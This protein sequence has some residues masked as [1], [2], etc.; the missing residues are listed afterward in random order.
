MASSRPGP[1]ELFLATRP[2]S[3]LNSVSKAVVGGVLGL[4]AAGVSARTISVLIAAVAGT[5]AFQASENLIN[6]YYDVKRGADAPGSPS[7][8]V[9]PHSVY[10][11]G[12]SLGQVRLLGLSL[13]ALGSALVAIVTVLAARPLLPAF[14]AAGAALLVT[15]SGPVGL[16]YRGLGEVDVFLATLVMVLGSYYAVS[17]ELSTRALIVGVPV[18]LLAASVAL[19]D[20]VR[21]YEWDRSH[22]V[23]TMAVRLGARASRALYCALVLSAV[24][25]PS[26]I[27]PPL[28]ALTLASLPLAALLMASVYG[29]GPVGPRAA[30]RLRF[31]M[32][33]TYSA[34]L[35]AAV[36]L[37]A[38]RF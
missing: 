35:I 22:G 18:G 15:Y 37:S 24:V 23:G 11:L 2:Y 13:L 12:L 30:V 27:A 6:D 36:A 14:L 26:I 20:D 7:T 16:K 31:Y 33:M 29:R 1:R 19:A 4:L 10:T 34:L 28:G 25:A 17:G 8:T 21:D 38:V 3:L 5:V 32:T 9:R